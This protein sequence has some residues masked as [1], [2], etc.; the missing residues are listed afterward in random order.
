MKNRIKADCYRIW[1]EKSLVIPLG[2]MILLGF[3]MSYLAKDVVGQEGMTLTLSSLT[4]FV[5]LFF[6]S[7]CNL[8]WGEDYTY[9]TIN[10]TLVKNKSRVAVFSCKLIESLGLA[11]GY[12]ALTFF[13][14]LVIRHLLGGEVDIYRAVLIVVKQIPFYFCFT[15]LSLFLFQYLDKIYQAFLAYTMLVL[16]FDNLV[17]YVVSNFL[18]SELVSHFFLF[19]QVKL[20]TPE[21]H[22]LSSASLVAVAFGMLY[23]VLSHLLFAKREFK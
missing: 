6:S 10:H 7:S 19:N 17:S 12:V 22:F 4:G 23:L 16:M 15:M 21:S 8:F 13:I 3:L 1:R 11:I 14:A 9:R 18:D 2:L 5:P 20:I